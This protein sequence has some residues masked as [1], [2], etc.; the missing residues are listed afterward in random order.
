MRNCRTLQSSLVCQ[1]LLITLLRIHS[2][3]RSSLIYS[4]THTD[5]QAQSTCIFYKAF[6]IQIKQDSQEHLQNASFGCRLDKSAQPHAVRPFHKLSDSQDSCCQ[7]QM[8]A[9][10]H[11]LRLAC[12]VKYEGI[13]HAPILHSKQNRRRRELSSCA[14][15]TTCTHIKHTQIALSVK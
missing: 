5:E 6:F 1:S 15:G 8:R 10:D 4:S 7:P 11:G 3:I 9:Q 13:N 2:L 14:Q 12:A